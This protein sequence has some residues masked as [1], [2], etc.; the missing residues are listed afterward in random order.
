MRMHRRITTADVKDFA[1]HTP[2]DEVDVVRE[3]D[4]VYTRGVL[5]HGSGVTTTRIL[6][7]V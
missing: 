4:I 7:Q 2:Q 5:T 1:V 3:E 6:L